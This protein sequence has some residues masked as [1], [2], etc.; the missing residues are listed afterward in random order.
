MLSG[1]YAKDLLRR[2]SVDHRYKSRSERPFEIQTMGS[3]AA[4]C[5][6]SSAPSRLSLLNYRFDGYGKIGPVSF[7]NW[8][9]IFLLEHRRASLAPCGR[10]WGK[11][12]RGGAG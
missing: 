8:H 9:G 1:N 2:R 11:I 6:P 4:P 3:K 12:T 5:P 10:I 7:H